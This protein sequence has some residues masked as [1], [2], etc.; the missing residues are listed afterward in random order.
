V[1]LP[2][3][4]ADGMTCSDCGGVVTYDPE[5]AIFWHVDPDADCQRGRERAEWL[6]KYSKPRKE[7]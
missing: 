7:A 4:T 1:K 6:A 2:A 5:Q 3:Y